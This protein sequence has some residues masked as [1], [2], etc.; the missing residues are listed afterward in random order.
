MKKWHIITIA[1]VI[2]FLMYYIQ[3]STSKKQQE[4]STTQVSEENVTV[5]PTR[6]PDT[7]LPTVVINGKLYRVEGIMKS[8][9]IFEE[10][11]YVGMVESEVELSRTPSEELESN[12][13]PIGTLIYKHQKEDDV[14][15]CLVYNEI[16]R[17]YR[18][19]RAIATD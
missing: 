4:W 19:S 15:I 3:D 10:T 6:P 7:A 18:Y 5:K 13:L 16:S 12:V 2:V 14:F 17:T 9:A 8:E 11:D 1:I